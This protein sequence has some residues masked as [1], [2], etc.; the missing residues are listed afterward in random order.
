MF[1]LCRTSGRFLG[2]NVPPEDLQ[3]IPEH[4]LS[5]QEPEPFWHYFLSACY[6]IFMFISLIGNGLVIYIFA[7][8]V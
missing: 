7:R 3:Y 8:S 6:I 2:W 4:W 5:Y 1:V